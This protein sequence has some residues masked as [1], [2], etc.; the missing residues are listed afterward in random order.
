MPMCRGKT[1]SGKDNKIRIAKRFSPCS[2]CVL[3][4]F[5]VKEISAQQKQKKRPPYWD[6]LLF[7]F[8][9]VFHAGDQDSGF[10]FSE[11]ALIVNKFILFSIRSFAIIAFEGIGIRIF[12]H[13]VFNGTG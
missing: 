13:L 3:P 7:N 11:G 8:P 5:V 2:S 12:G 1:V 10:Y 4:P 9:P 6:G